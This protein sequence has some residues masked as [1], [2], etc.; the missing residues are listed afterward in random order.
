MP[1]RASIMSGTSKAILSICV[2]LI[3]SLV[4][5]YGMTPPQLSTAEPIVAPERP[6]M[7]GG[8]PTDKLAKLGF[9]PIAADLTTEPANVP[10]IVIEEEVDLAVVESSDEEMST[11]ES[12]PILVDE[13]ITKLYVVR[14]GETLG[15]IASRELGSFRMWVEIATIN[16]ISDPSRIMPGRT[17]KMPVQKIVA[18]KIEQA[19]TEVDS[20]I[21]HRVIE[22]E[23]LSS[24]AD[25]Y[26]DDANKYYIIANANPSVNPNSLQIGDVLVIPEN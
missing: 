17:L 20:N 10:V 21:Q 24:I 11:W 4:V 6:S 5:Y 14:D 3:A 9:P 26:Y 18:P 2:L 23:T 22:G 15:E 8:D 1:R 19:S 12:N 16:G 25:D 7:F 13:K